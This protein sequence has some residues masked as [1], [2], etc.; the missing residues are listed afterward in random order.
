MMT[1]HDISVHRK[2]TRRDFLRLAALAGGSFVTTVVPGERTASAEPLPPSVPK[3]PQPQE[4]VQIEFQ[5][6]HSIDT[7]DALW[8]EMYLIFKEQ[9][10]DID[11]LLRPQPEHYMDTIL[12]EIGAGTAADVIGVCCQWGPYFIQQGETVDLQPYIDSQLPLDCQDDFAAKQ[13]ERWLDGAGHLHLMP[14]YLGTLVLFWNK[15]MF[16][17]EGQ[18]YPPASW[19]SAWTHDE[20]LAAMGPFCVD[21]GGGERIRW[22]SWGAS[23]WLDR[24]QQHIR[25]W[26]GHVVDPADNR[27]CM[28]AEQ[29]GQ[30]ALE[31]WRARVWDDNVIPRRDQVTSYHGGALFPDQS[32]AMMEDGSWQIRPMVDA[33]S[34][35]WDI[36]P[37]PR[38]PVEQVTMATTDGWFVWQG[39]QPEHEDACWELM[40]FLSSV[41]YGRA[42]CRHA[43]S[44]PSRLSNYPYWYDQMRTQHPALVDVNLELFQ[45]AVDQDLGE[46]LEIFAD[47]GTAMDILNPVFDEV[48]HQGQKSVSAIAAACMEVSE[49]MGYPISRTYLPLILG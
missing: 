13:F 42:L 32:I 7:I 46:T 38:G 5:P 44:Q 25:C 21:S 31:W 17:T 45:Q 41:E 34:F 29:P 49:A 43:L 22:G 40:E 36:A 16:D 8:A 9:H 48:F 12:A 15:D 28:L 19:D 24:I 14:K 20:Y 35:T 11:V 27:H 6:R 3:S 39:T 30:A 4:T 33:C 23:V 37:F 26:G 47:H 1:G 10:P 18:P 2:L